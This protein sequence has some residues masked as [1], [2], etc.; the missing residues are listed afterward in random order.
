M[1]YELQSWAADARIWQKRRKIAL[2]LSEYSLS[3]PVQEYSGSCC[4]WLAFIY[5]ESPQFHEMDK[6]RYLVT[7]T[8]C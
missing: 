8:D 5:V 7:S 1:E 3:E 4:W 6:T 2:V